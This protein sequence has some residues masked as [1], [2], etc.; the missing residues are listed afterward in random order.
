MPIRELCGWGIA[1]SL[2][3]YPVVLLASFVVWMDGE[4]P[5][6]S[7]FCT[8]LLGLCGPG[9]YLASRRLREPAELDVA[10]ADERAPVLVLHAYERSR[11]PWWR[12]ILVPES[13]LRDL[14]DALHER[15][16]RR[17][18]TTVGPILTLAR[19]RPPPTHGRVALSKDDG[20]WERE[21]RAR[22]VSSR[23]VA[24]VVDGTPENRR[25]L[26]IV[27]PA[28]DPRRL[29]LIT[30]PN[31]DEA[32][33]ARW[34]A[35]REKLPGLPE[36]D[37]KCA[38]VR[39]DADRV[40]SVIG[41]RSSSPGARRA[42]LGVPSLIVRESEVRPRPEP[43]PVTGLLSAVPIVFA[44]GASVMT[45]VAIRGV[46]GV[47][48]DP[49]EMLALGV[50]TI[51]C[52][53]LLAVMSRRVMRLVPGN[54]L[55]MVLVAS[56]PWLATEVSRWVDSTHPWHYL[57]NLETAANGAA[58]SGS[59]LLAT[60]LV[61]SGASLVRRAPGRRPSFA[62]FGVATVL[63][64]ATL[65]TMLDDPDAVAALLGASA[66]A[67]I[68]MALATVAASGEG[69]RRHAPLSIGSAATA[70][71]ALA[72]WGTSVMHD[73]WGDLGHIARNTDAFSG[74]P[75]MDQVQVL[76]QIDRALPWFILAIPCVVLLVGMLFRG[77][78][79][80]VGAGNAF[81]LLPLVLLLPMAN[82]AHQRA[83]TM[84]EERSAALGAGLFA[85]AAG[86]LLP[87]LTFASTGYGDQPS[88]P[89]DIILDRSG[90]I[91]EGRRVASEVELS[92][93]GATGGPR[94][95]RAISSSLAAREDRDVVRIAA[96]PNANGAA[97]LATCRAAW[98]Q[99]ATYAELVMRGTGGRP[100]S[101][102]V[103]QAWLPAP[104][105]PLE[106]RVMLY[107]DLDGRGAYLTSTDGASVEIERRP[108]GRLD[109][110]RLRER[111]YDRKRQEPNRRD[112]IIAVLGG[113]SADDVLQSLVAAS[114]AG[115]PELALTDSSR[116]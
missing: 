105:G 50:I 5:A 13:L 104:G 35:L 4:A 74:P 61:L 78:A 91:A 8:L 28:I 112:I 21:L 60:S 101:V 116:L 59:L 54:E 97:L 57:D 1:F 30:P 58:Y 68:A 23:L 25:E 107:L 69:A 10:E 33:A 9:A 29:V 6:V 83:R 45:P 46:N 36:L 72:A 108:D 89:V 48:M 88:G 12:R 3:V 65:A 19:P 66:L 11:S 22:M 20:E 85:P 63:P 73:Q 44:L 71:L 37:G 102:R 96:A 90:A 113:A 87:G 26:D 14:G 99:G 16:L 115:F 49:G 38:A 84:L 67:A 41:A 109:I 111:L 76:E 18:L 55:P 39:F 110:E 80:R 98:A 100:T 32:F 40:P 92:S 51:F 103:R 42:I 27:A 82:T 70:A 62:I 81:A 86:D 106:G 114:A 95:S 24:I 79:T 93:F 75:L 2:L 15:A 47:R 56:F 53:A 34:T 52:G 7:F 17:S 64:F 43:P 31:M 94:L 77:R